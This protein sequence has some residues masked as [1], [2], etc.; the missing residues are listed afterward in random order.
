[1]QSPRR[2]LE[3]LGDLYVKT[4]NTKAMTILLKKFPGDFTSTQFR[5]LPRNKAVAILQRISNGA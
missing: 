1:M 5:L 2:N 3:D 4:Q